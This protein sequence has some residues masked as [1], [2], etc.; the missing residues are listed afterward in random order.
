M[1]LTFTIG[2][3]IT[4]LSATLGV[5]AALAGLA[6]IVFT[7]KSMKEKKRTTSKSFEETNDLLVDTRL[8]DIRYEFDRHKFISRWNTYSSTL[9]TIGQF[10]VGGVL[11]SSF[12]Q[13]SLSPNL[14]GLLGVIVLIT[15][16]INQRF[17]PD[18][19]AAQ[20]KQR[21]YKARR[22]M[23]GIE[24][25]IFAIQNSTEGAPLVIEV[26]RRASNGLTELEDKEIQAVEHIAKE[27]S[28]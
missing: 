12:I 8:N 18:L 5:G 24:D 28:K 17:R 22:L 26:R 10:V 23:R 1:A 13:E 7:K 6:S 16:L 27:V 11:A 15:S 14:I 20:A 9:L 21:M 25:D 19:H 3:F 2:E 4:E